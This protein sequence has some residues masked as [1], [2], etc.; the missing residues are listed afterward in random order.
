MMK[1]NSLLIAAAMVISLSACERNAENAEEQA[2]LEKPADTMTVQ[3]SDEDIRFEQESSSYYTTTDQR[4]AMLDARMDSLQ[5]QASRAR[6]AEKTRL[7]QRYETLRARRDSLNTNYSGLRS[8][9][10]DTWQN[11]RTG[12]DNSIN[13]IERE[14]NELRIGNPTDNTGTAG[15]GTTKE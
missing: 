15:T 6:G 11:L 9:A 14:F 10:R 1:K 5:A 13:A 4:I 7:Q 8:A 3:R 12:V 2:N